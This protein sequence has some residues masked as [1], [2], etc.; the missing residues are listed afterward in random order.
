MASTIVNTRTPK[1][2][3]HS[4]TKYNRLPITRN[5]DHTLTIP[6]TVGNLTVDI[7]LDTGS[8]LNLLRT[9]IY[10]EFTPASDWIKRVEAQPTG[11]TVDGSPFDISEYILIPR[12]FFKSCP[13]REFPIEFGIAPNLFCTA[14]LG[15]RVMETLKIRLD[16]GNRLLE[17]PRI[18]PPAIVAAIHHEDL[19]HLDQWKNFITA[20]KKG[21]TYKLKELEGA[22]KLAISTGPNQLNSRGLMEGKGS[23]FLQTLFTYLMGFFKNF[24]HLSELSSEK[25]LETA[26]IAQRTLALPGKQS[27]KFN[28]F[29]NKI[30]LAKRERNRKLLEDLIPRAILNSYTKTMSKLSKDLTNLHESNSLN[31]AKQ[32]GEAKI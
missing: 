21:F 3:G 19:R 11:I 14:L 9:D 23:P 13:E 22:I 20:P 30:L 16:I 18:K 29:A 15:E 7:M 32:Q 28:K 4:T 26:S 25:Q 31:L 17:I 2:T 1:T 6:M 8:A 27:E 10:K 5:A 12:C 24:P